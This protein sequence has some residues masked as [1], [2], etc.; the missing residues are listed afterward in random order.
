[1]NG[2]LTLDS[3]A[4]EF[5]TNR[6]YLSK[7]VNELKGNNFSQYIN[8]LRIKYIIE[9]LK[10][11]PKLQK[12][13]IAGIAEEAGFNNSESFTNSF[14]KLTETLPSYYIKA[15]KQKD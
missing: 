12:L 14:K 10:M 1:M 5:N 7:S 2:N 9:E 3:L 11:N 6:D 4:K 13:T 8:E 15:L